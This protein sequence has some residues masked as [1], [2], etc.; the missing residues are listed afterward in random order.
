MQIFVTY[1]VFKG[2]RCIGGAHAANVK[3]IPTV[4]CC[5]IILRFQ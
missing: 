1:V 4:L 2:V 5:H 3:A